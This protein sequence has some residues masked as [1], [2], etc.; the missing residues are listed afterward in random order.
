MAVVFEMQNPGH[1]APLD[2]IIPAWRVVIVGEN[3]QGITGVDEVAHLSG[4]DATP[5]QEQEVIE[6]TTFGGA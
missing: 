3:E 6:E 1:P 5:E 4:S 2:E